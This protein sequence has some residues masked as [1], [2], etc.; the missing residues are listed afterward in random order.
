MLKYMATSAA[1]RGAN[2]VHHFEKSTIQSIN[3][4]IYGDDTCIQYIII[5]IGDDEHFQA[6][7]A[8]G[9]RDADTIRS[10]V[11]ATIFVVGVCFHFA[12]IDDRMQ[13][14]DR[15][16]AYKLPFLCVVRKIAVI[17]LLGLL[18]FLTECKVDRS[19][20]VWSG[21]LGSYLRTAS[22]SCQVV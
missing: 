13:V 11:F 8:A 7:N 1:R 2:E 18:L 20:V 12:P 16:D 19:T 6:N 4:T 5:I 15:D 3:A 22:R 21:F 9:R 17:L 14:I 10:S